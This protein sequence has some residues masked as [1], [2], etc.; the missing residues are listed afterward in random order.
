MDCR[1]LNKATHKY[2]FPLPFI[3][4]ILDRLAGKKLYCFL[5]G[6]SWFNQIFIAPEDQKVQLLH[7]LMEPLP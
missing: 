7:A 2:N 5:D 1:K 6:Y 4:Q 3:D